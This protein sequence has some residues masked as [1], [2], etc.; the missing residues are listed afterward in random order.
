M[1]IQQ[2]VSILSS[3]EKAVQARQTEMP[4]P[5]DVLIAVVFAWSFF[6]IGS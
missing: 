3:A 4:N 6:L 2:K 5:G 1:A